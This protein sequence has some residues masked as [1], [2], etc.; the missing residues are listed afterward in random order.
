MGTKHIGILV[1]H[2]NQESDLPFPLS[3][4]FSL[5]SFAGVSFFNYIGQLAR[6]AIPIVRAGNLGT[7]FLG[8]PCLKSFESDADNQ[9]YLHGIWK[10]EE[11]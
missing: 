8:I 4:V 7:T 11:R 6:Y 2:S 9:R 1:F 10:V 5:Q 3:K